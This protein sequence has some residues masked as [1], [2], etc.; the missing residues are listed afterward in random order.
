MR[1]ADWQVDVTDRSVHWIAPTLDDRVLQGTGELPLKLHARHFRP[2]RLG[3]D[4]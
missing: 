2:F 4:R 3:I 1:R